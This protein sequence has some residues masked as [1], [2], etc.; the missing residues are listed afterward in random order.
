MGIEEIY[1]WYRR[2]PSVCTDTRKIKAGDIYLAL[3]GPHFNGN[4]FAEKALEAGASCVIV[5]ESTGTPPE[6]TISVP[7]TLATL[8]HLALYHR[9]QL[10]CKVMAIAGSNG[11]TTTKELIAAVL[12]TTRKVFAT[13]GNLNNHI[14]VPLS[15]LM[16]APDTEV[17]VLELGANH[18]GETRDLCQWVEPD[19]GLITNNGK[20]HLEGYGNLE[21]VKRGNGE[22]Y[23]YLRSRNRPVLVCT[24]EQDLME[25]SAGMERIT[26]GSASGDAVAGRVIEAAPF[27]KVACRVNGETLMLETH[28]AGA[29]N[30]NN[31]LAAVCAGYYFGIS[32][33]RIAQGI[34]GYVPSSNRSQVRQEGSNTFIMDCYNANPSSMSASLRSFAAMPFEN[35]IAVLGDMAELGAASVAEHRLILELTHSLPL[36]E[37]FYCGPIFFACGEKATPH[38]RFFPTLE[39]LQEYFHSRSFQNAAFLLKA[40]RSM[41]LERLLNA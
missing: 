8:Q 10:S 5:D 4:L 29:Y 24:N 27:L 12:R 35:K 28:L 23:D 3:K 37:V 14:G 32:P 13:P 40:S 7:D 1:A 21:N 9:R 15:L 19:L 34:A 30:L 16:I 22:L 33:D 38:H 17:A 36:Q 25:L 39:S 18:L 11:K 41:G 6:K 20:D 2:H 26:Y 31:V